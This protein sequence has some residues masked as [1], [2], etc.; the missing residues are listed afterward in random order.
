MLDVLRGHLLPRAVV[1]SG[2]GDVA[3]VSVLRPKEG[4]AAVSPTGTA[5]GLALGHPELHHRT[6]CGGGA[7]PL[8]TAPQGRAG[9]SQSY[10]YWENRCAAVRGGL[11]LLL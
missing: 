4:W 9:T 3:A 8:P 2:G 6:G 5:A 1:S 10:G 7:G 11:Q